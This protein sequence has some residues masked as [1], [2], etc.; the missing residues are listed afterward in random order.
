M[1]KIIPRAL[2]F[3]MFAIIR[4]ALVI[5]GWFFVPLMLLSDGFHRTSGLWTPI[6]GDAAEVP[7]SYSKSRWTKYV[8]MAW[9]NPTNGMKHWW[10][11]PIPEVQPNPDRLI[12]GYPGAIAEKSASRFMASD[13]FWEY[14]WMRRI[15]WGK[16][17]YFEFRIGWKFVDG[18]E[19]F[20]P[21]IQLGPRS[22]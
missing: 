22:S 18:N 20:F 8:W 17:R 11:Q 13:L 21:T 10:E 14:W 19:E 12:R 3:F 1:I 6:W 4:L 7:A 16:Y 9:R 2:F 15:S 5:V